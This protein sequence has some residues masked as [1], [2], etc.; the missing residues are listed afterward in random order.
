M[1][2]L[3][4]H[5][6]NYVDTIYLYTAVII[7]AFMYNKICNTLDMLFQYIY[8]VYGY[9]LKQLY[10]NKIANSWIMLENSCHIL[11]KHQQ[12][13]SLVI[14]QFVLVRYHLV[15]F[16]ICIQPQRNPWSD[17]WFCYSL[18]WVCILLLQTSLPLTF[19]SI[20][21]R[22]SMINAKIVA[23]VGRG[24]SGTG[25]HG[26]RASLSRAS[27]APSNASSDGRDWQRIALRLPCNKM[28]DD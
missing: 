5:L 4:M 16:A 24:G 6:Y 27:R 12:N 17:Y 26:V 2:S 10:I 13:W 7:N 28:P 15:Q 21:C 9:S 11:L 3:S 23:A 22:Q 19:L 14:S 18:T 20:S 1:Q 8:I 25:Y